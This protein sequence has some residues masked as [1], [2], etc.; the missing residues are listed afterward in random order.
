MTDIDWIYEKRPLGFHGTQ[1]RID[2]LAWLGLN[3]I[4]DL[5]RHILEA[6]PSVCRFP[7][8]KAS[9]FCPGFA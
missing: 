5:D 4:Q 1:W 9:M 6:E 2:L 7:A 3:L 8:S